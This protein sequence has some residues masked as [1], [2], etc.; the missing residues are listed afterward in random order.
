MKCL[1]CNKEL[2]ISKDNLWHKTC[3]KKFFG[4]EEFPEITLDEKDLKKLVDISIN[5]G[6]TVQGVQKKI[7]LGFAKSNNKRL[8]LS[9]YPLGYILKPESTEYPEIAITEYVSMTLANLVNLKTVPFGLIKINEK[10]AYITKRVDRFIK[11]KKV[12]LAQEDFC[13]LQNKL[14]EDKYKGSYEKVAKTIDLYSSNNEIDK[15]YLFNSLI[16]SFIIGNSDMHL[17]NFSLLETSEKSNTY[18]LA[19]FYDLLSVKILLPGDKEE[20]ALTLNGKKK[21]ITKNDFLI[22]G[23]QIGINKK[24]CLNLINKMISYKNEMLKIIDES[25][26]NDKLKNDFKN[27]ILERIDRLN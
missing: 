10:Y 11:N 3:I 18:K 19:P 21:N 2:D 16:F 26:L 8:T 14:T 20:F 12:I 22:F 1:C 27:L 9:N 6:F 5:D 25:L 7:S 13:Q 17:K 4:T 24:I 15:V 23:E